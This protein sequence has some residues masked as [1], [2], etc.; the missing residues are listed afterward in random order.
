MVAGHPSL[1]VFMPIE[2]ISQNGPS[3]VVW[4][5]DQPPC[6]TT[7]PVTGEPENYHFRLLWENRMSVL[8]Y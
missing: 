8:Q 3:A 5:R 6:H 2:G 1:G 7:R 4:N